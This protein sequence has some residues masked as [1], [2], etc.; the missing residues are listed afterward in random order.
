MIKVIGMVASGF[1]EP[2]TRAL[3]MVRSSLFGGCNFV[4]RMKTREDCMASSLFIYVCLFMPEIH[5]VSGLPPAR[6]VDW[7]EIH[8]MPV[9]RR[10]VPIRLQIFQFC[11]I[12]RR[13]KTF[14]A[15][16]RPSPSSSSVLLVGEI[17]RPC[18]S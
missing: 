17:L 1:I 3:L 5:E 2:V 16:P 12:R 13:S 7:R 10:M 15:I 18:A 11:S 14:A 8:V 9:L 4:F 6:T